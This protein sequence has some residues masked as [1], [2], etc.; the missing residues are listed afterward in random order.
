M[1]KVV[2]KSIIDCRLN[3][4]KKKLFRPYTVNVI[5]FY[6]RFN[7]FSARLCNC[8]DGVVFFNKIVDI[9]RQWF[10][11]FMLFLLY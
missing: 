8:S 11:L 6:L 10:L 4:K 3:K 1:A 7:D 9:F 5:D 2:L